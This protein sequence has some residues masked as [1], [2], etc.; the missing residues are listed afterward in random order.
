VIELPNLTLVGQVAGGRRPL[1]SGGGIRENGLVVCA[2]NFELEGIELRD[3][4][5]NGVLVWS[6]SNVTL[7]EVLADHTGEYGLFVVH[8]SQVVIEGSLAIGASDTGIYV[9]QSQE[10]RVSAS[11]ARENVS[12]FEIENSSRV[13]LEDNDAHGNTAGI[14]VFVLPDLGQKRGTDNTVRGNRVI[15]N[16]LANVAPPEEIVS[17]VPAG[18]GIL[19][20]AADRTEVTDNEVR[21]NRSVGIAVIGLKE[22]FPTRPQFDVGTESEG[23]WIHG[24][25]VEGNGTDPDPALEA[26]GLPGVDLLWGLSG[27]DNAW[28]QPQ[29]TRF[30]PLLPSRGWPKPLQVGYWRGLNLLR[31]YVWD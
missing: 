1:L 29:G 26:A 3:Y 5:A 4:T 14:L 23:S 11:E 25:R 10:V 16:N 12:G 22:L 17:Q 18:T 15:A 9:G 13:I 21:D 7:R 20:M 19:I 27:W 2:A 24:N 6:T 28:D 8:S 30:P 31:Q